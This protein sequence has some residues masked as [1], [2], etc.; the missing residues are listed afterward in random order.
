MEAKEEAATEDT[1]AG[2][3][4][5]KPHK[6]DRMARPRSK[7][8]PTKV[9]GPWML[10]RVKTDAQIGINKLPRV[11]NVCGHTA[12]WRSPDTHLGQPHHWPGASDLMDLAAKGREVA[13]DMQVNGDWQEGPPEARRIPEEEDVALLELGPTRSGPKL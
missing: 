8:E 9:A 11:G 10:T 12:S 2:T 5:V 1:E 4:E 3:S 6:D 7:G 13:N